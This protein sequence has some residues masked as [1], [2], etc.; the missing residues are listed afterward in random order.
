MEVARGYPRDARYRRA[1]EAQVEVESTPNWILTTPTNLLGTVVGRGVT[2]TGDT[3]AMT[4]IFARQ[5]LR[6]NWLVP[7]DALESGWIRQV[8]NALLTSPDVPESTGSMWL[9]E[10]YVADPRDQEGRHIALRAP[11]EV[12]QNLQGTLYVPQAPAPFYQHEWPNPSLGYPFPIELRGF[13]FNPNFAQPVPFVQT[14]WPNPL[15][16]ARYRARL[17][18]WIENGFDDSLGPTETIPPGKQRDELPPRGAKPAPK[19]NL[20]W[21]QQSIQSVALLI[22]PFSQHEWPNPVRHAPATVEDLTWF[23][24]LSPDTHDPFP[25][26]DMTNP[27]RAIRQPVENRT[28]INPITFTEAEPVG[29]SVFPEPTN[30]PHARTNDLTWISSVQREEE[31]PV[32]KQAEDYRAPARIVQQPDLLPSAALTMQRPI[33]FAQY[34]WPNPVRQPIMVENLT[35]LSFGLTEQKPVGASMLDFR[36]PARTVP[37][38]ADPQ[39]TTALESDVFPFVQRDW[40][41]P[42][43]AASRAD[44]TWI[45]SVLLTAHPPVGVQKT[46]LPTRSVSAARQELQ[47][48]NLLLMPSQP[49]LPVGVQ[50]TPDPVRALLRLLQDEVN[51]FNALI[52]GGIPFAQHDWP[53]PTRSLPAVV[54]EQPSP[55]L[56]LIDSGT[57]PFAQYDWPRPVLPRW[58]DRWHLP[59]EN[60]AVNSAPLRITPIEGSFSP[61][62]AFAGSFSP[63]VAIRGS[64]SPTIRV[65]GE[66]NS[67]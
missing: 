46:E 30:V 34:D 60:I 47:P 59:S 3:A 15:I 52:L 39:N 61:T 45:N 51:P 18:G 4:A 36:A 33:P 24:R 2:Q 19:E 53:N 12:W 62:A 28:W 20:T 48:P 41:V 6:A 25:S 56:T 5:A 64:F 14:D 50:L 65:T 31:I 23:Q 27:V 7:V 63:T 26:G 13:I 66:N 54:Q 35:W 11:P 42:Q 8:P 40:P 49:P 16:G 32:G 10:D 29:R 57:Q 17:L 58:T 55:F 67:E 9:Y 37:Q 21:I 22:Q 43:R 1:I 44:Q 38:V